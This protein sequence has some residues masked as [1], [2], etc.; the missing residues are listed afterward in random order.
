MRLRFLLTLILSLAAVVS[1][2]N[3][4]VYGTWTGTPSATHWSYAPGVGPDTRTA[5][6]PTSQSL[7][8]PVFLAVPTSGNIRAFLTG[9]TASTGSIKVENNILTVAANNGN[10]P[11]K[12]SAY[13][14]GSTTTLNSLFFTLN[15]PNSPT[16]A[17][18]GLIIIGIGNNSAAVLTDNNQLTGNELPGLFTA[19]Q[20]GIGVT[21]I[22]ARYRGPAAP[23]THGYTNLT[24]L[25][26]KATDLKFE[27][28]SNNSTVTE[29][30]NRGGAPI[31]IG[32]NIFHIYVNGTQLQTGG[33]TLNLPFSGEVTGGTVLNSFV[34]TAANS[35]APS[36][37]A[38]TFNI[39]DLKVGS[40]VSVLPVALTDFTAKRQGANVKLDWATASEQNNQYFELFKSKTG[41]DD[42]V[43]V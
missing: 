34:F 19:I 1:T 16:N 22:T 4:Q 7:I 15:I 17:T 5:T 35:T 39:T 36:N 20:L 32:P 24:P 41:K 13:S 38:L 21:N 6:P 10:S 25:L 27:I 23:T 8:A 9:S 26:T 28:Y 43:S 29:S 33:G 37:S 14:I 3:A 30:Y 12:I 42:F 18:D 40:G 2:V 11:H 31:N